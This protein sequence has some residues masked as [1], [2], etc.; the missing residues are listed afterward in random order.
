MILYIYMKNTKQKIKRSR[1][2]KYYSNYMWVQQIGSQNREFNRFLYTFKNK[3]YNCWK[4]IVFSPS[5]KKI[6]NPPLRARASLRANVD[7][8]NPPV[9]HTRVYLTPTTQY[10]FCLV[11]D[12]IKPSV[13]WRNGD[14]EAIWLCDTPRPPPSRRLRVGRLSLLACRTRSEF[15]TRSR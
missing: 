6:L 4:I 5:Q 13:L 12:T 11:D 1:K 2:N 14:D 3:Y 7:E 9:R 15:L 8:N 10:T